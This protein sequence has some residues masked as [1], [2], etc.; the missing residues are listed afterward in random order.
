MTSKEKI[1]EILDY[2]Q[3]SQINWN[4]MMGLKQDLEELVKIAQAEVVYS[5]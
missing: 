1:A 2:V 4:F 3:C 5:E